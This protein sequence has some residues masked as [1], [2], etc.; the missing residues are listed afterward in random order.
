MPGA[1]GIVIGHNDR[2]AWGITASQADTE[3]AYE[4]EFSSEE[5]ASY[6]YDGGW[7]KAEIIPEFIRV[8]GRDGTVRE[9]VFVT[10]HGPV[11]LRKRN[12]PNRG[13]TLRSTVLERD[14]LLRAGLDMAQAGTA[15]E[16]RN[17]LARWR[18]PSVNFVFADVTGAIGYQLAGLL[19]NRPVG[20]GSTP[21]LGSV[22][23]SEWAGFIP[24]EALPSTVDPEEGAVVTAN[25]K[26]GPI[27]PRYVL[28]GEWADGYRAQRIWD[29]LA[30]AQH[31]VASFQAMHQDAVTNAAGEL[32]E[33]LKDTPPDSFIARRYWR[34][35]L[36][37][38]RALTVGSREGA[39][40]EA[41]RHQLYRNLLSPVL[42]EQVNDF[43]GVQLHPLGVSAAFQ[44]RGS[45]FFLAQLRAV[46]ASGQ[47]SGA[48]GRLITQSFEGAVAELTERLGP[49][50]ARWSWGRLHQVT[51]RHVLGR[52]PVLGR[53]LNRGPF[54]A[55]GDGDTPHQ[56]SFS[57][58]A[59]YEA[60]R[61][62]P[63][64]R[65]IADTADWDR[66]VSV[67]APGQSGQFSDRHYDDQLKL[68]RAGDYHPMPFSRPAVEAA[69]ARVQHFR[70]G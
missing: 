52:G 30:G 17:A 31:S 59:P 46:K 40:Y 21:P 43:F 66:C 4:V 39:L 3:D 61:W 49:D 57:F 9:D 55:P 45:S 26:P 38:D 16:F 32:Q 64:F 37:W 44:F 24:F 22:E 41:V 28:A 23:G 60:N 47:Q 12:A 42:G 2:V 36:A 51:F 68:W 70:P 5:P 29:G 19:P 67:Q 56:A 54:P 8:K 33:L 65:F 7:R 69:A 6:R 18:A 15:G 63:T 10:H 58:A 53:L 48:F 50:D 20:T 11:L 35:F 14:S 62:L 27:D 13:Y 34:D 25:N 1:P